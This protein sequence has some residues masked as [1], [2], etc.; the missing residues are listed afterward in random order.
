[1][2]APFIPGSVD[3]KTTESFLLMQRDVLDASV[4]MDDG[5]LHAHVTVHDDSHWSPG[6]L[7]LACAEE[8]GLHQTPIEILLYCARKRAA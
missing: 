8:L 5:R 4:W 2:I 3:P 1:M 7:R 6:N